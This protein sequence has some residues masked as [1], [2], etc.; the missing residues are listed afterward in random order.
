[1]FVILRRQVIRQRHPRLLLLLHQQLRLLFLQERRPSLVPPLQ[2]RLA[3]F[4]TRQRPQVSLK[5]VL[6]APAR[7][8][9]VF[10]TLRRLHPPHPLRPLRPPAGGIITTADTG[11][12]SYIFLVNFIADTLHRITP[13]AAERM[14]RRSRIPSFD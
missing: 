14:H 12:E 8:R 10:L 2:L 4:C 6:Y 1:M 7:I 13:F 3:C 9:L 5:Y 11:G